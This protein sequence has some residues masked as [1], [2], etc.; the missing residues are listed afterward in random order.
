MFSLKIEKGGSVSALF[1]C[2]LY[3]YE[4]AE[5]MLGVDPEMLS[6]GW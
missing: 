5:N 1:A 6:P 4:N 3:C 2:R